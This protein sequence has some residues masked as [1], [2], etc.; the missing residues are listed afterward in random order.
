MS[1]Q[2]SLLNSASLQAAAHCLLLLTNNHMIL[3][4]CV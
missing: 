3:K 1:D 4:V 2:Y